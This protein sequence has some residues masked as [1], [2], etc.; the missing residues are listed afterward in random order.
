MFLGNSVVFGYG[1]ETRDALPAQ[2]ERLAGDTR[3]F[4]A[5]VNGAENGDSYLVG[6]AG[7]DSVDTLYVQL[8]RHG[9]ARPILGTLIPI[10][11]ADARRFALD[12]TDPMEVKLRSLLGRVWRLYAVNDRLQAAFFGTSARQY[13]YLHKRE[14]LLAARRGPLP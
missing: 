5:A 8:T 9:H 13:L 7:I 12:R 1:L 3:V 4:N 6:K 11:D 14:L 2:F 10:D